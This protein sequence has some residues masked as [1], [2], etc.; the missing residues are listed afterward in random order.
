[1]ARIIA[2]LPHAEMLSRLHAALRLTAS[3]GAKHPL[4]VCS[5]WQE[6]RRESSERAVQL[7]IFDP[8]LDAG[9]D[10]RGCTAFHERFPSVVL[11][12]YGCFTR[13]HARD[14]LLLGQLGVRD[15][16]V[17]GEDESPVALS[18]RIG[19]AL[20]GGVPDTVL[21]L[22][23]DRFPP[24][25]RP[26]VGRILDAATNPLSPREAASLYHRHP[27]TLWK[28]LRKEGLPSLNRLIRWAR[29]FHAAHLL[30]DPHRSVDNV[31][32]ALNFPSTASLRNQFRRYAGLTPQEIRSGGGLSLLVAV[33]GEELT[34]HG[35]GEAALGEA[36]VD[37]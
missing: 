7:V 19:T 24:G 35:A 28:Q 15:L 33:F 9:T 18:R 2:L 16:V 6:A 36:C 5:D 4:V 12:P 26:L 1:M 13:T 31:G 14:L 23:G 21:A 3:R 29:L 34:Q 25:L 11:L 32:L 20:G 22:I 37:G 17:R 10:L 27:N 8:D 30:E